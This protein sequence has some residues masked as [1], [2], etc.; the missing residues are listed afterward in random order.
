MTVPPLS[1]T[2][3]MPA[4]S[5]SPDSAGALFSLEDHSVAVN[6]PDVALSAKLDNF[7]SDGYD[8][9]SIAAGVRHLRCDGWFHRAASEAWSPE[10]AVS[11]RRLRLPVSL[12][13]SMAASNTNAARKSISTKNSG[14]CLP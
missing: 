7:N 5:L 4:T 1:S 3:A 10:R 6:C 12:R 2:A 9:T 8:P 14:G 11:S 13:I